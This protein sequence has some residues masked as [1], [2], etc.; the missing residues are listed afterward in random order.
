MARLKWLNKLEIERRR[1]LFET[2]RLPRI[3]KELLEKRH[4]GIGAPLGR[5]LPNIKVDWLGR[6]EK[7]RYNREKLERQFPG[8][9]SKEFFL[10]LPKGGGGREGEVR[11]LHLGKENV[12]ISS[13]GMHWYDLIIKK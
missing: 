3:V 8:I 5:Q 1:K 11:R 9:F 13:S 10:K 4:L 2:K 6:I 7:W 12:F